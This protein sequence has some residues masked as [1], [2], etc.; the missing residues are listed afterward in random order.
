MLSINPIIRDYNNRPS[1]HTLASF[2]LNQAHSYTVYSIYIYLQY[3]MYHTESIL[4]F[5]LGITEIF[6]CVVK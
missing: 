5:D 1:C 6:G 4:H 2:I 3:I